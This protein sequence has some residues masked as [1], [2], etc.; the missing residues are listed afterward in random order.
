MIF[1]SDITSANG[2]C[3][4]MTDVGDWQDSFE[5]TLEKHNLTLPFGRE[6]PEADGWKEWQIAL[7]RIATVNRF[8]LQL[9]GKW[10]AESPHIWRLFY[11]H[12]NDENHT[13][14]HKGDKVIVY[15]NDGDARY[16]TTCYLEGSFHPGWELMGDPAMVIEAKENMMKLQMTSGSF[17]TAKDPE[18]KSFI[19]LLRYWGGAWMWDNGTLVTN[20]LI[21]VTDRSYDKLKGRDI[22]RTGWIIFCRRT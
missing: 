3:P 1:L 6:Y 18:E 14:V 22:C 12:N 4:I 17:Y 8:L 5:G 9:L 13:K 21:V 11:F 15:G 19:D 16:S 10:C 7:T 20:T 2:R